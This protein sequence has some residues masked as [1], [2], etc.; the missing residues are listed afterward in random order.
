MP[1]WDHEDCDP[2][3][4]AE[5][6]RLYRMMNRLEPVIIQGQSDSKIARAIQILHDR[7]AEH[8]Q[9]EEELFITAD[10]DSRRV[11]LD[12]HRQLLE[13]LARL[14]RLPPQDE[15]ARKVLFHA[16]LEALVRHDNDVDAPLFSRRH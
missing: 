14:G 2:A 16:F 6:T 3:I 9:V 12:D 15:H 7:M 13:M 1:S 5:H 10:W 4:E 11:M 8:F